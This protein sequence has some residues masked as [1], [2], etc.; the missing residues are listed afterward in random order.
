M[1]PSSL[2][3]DRGV[4]AGVRV[5]DFGRYVAGPYCAT[6]LGDFGAEVIRIEKREGS[7]DRFL[8]PVSAEGEGALFLQMNRN[9]QSMTLDPASEAG[10]EVV[11]RL[12]STADVVVVNMPADA[13]AA[14]GLDYPTLQGLNPGIILVNLSAFGKDGPWRDRLGFDSIGQA[15]SGAVHL[16]GEPDRPYRA[17]VNWVDYATA[18]H[19]AF[20]V[21]IALR[22][23]TQSGLGQEVSGALLATAVALNNG[24]LIEQALTAP[25]WQAIG[26]RSFTS[27]PTDLFRTLDGWIAVHVVGQPLFRRWAR[28]MGDAAHWLDD[29]RFADDSSRG[30]N[31]AALSE[32]MSAWC[33]DKTRD[34]ALDALAAAK[35]P[36]GPVLSPAEVLVHP[37]VAALGLLQ[38]VDYPGLPS[39]APLAGAPVFLSRTPAEI[40]RRPPQL[41]EHTEDVLASL[42]YDAQAISELRRL[43]AI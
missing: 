26:N 29:P 39:P 5:L 17:Q 11:R 33:A 6:L 9:K 13:V 14:M 34:E 24:P 15:M 8:I 41:G 16:S 36:A 22:E 18:L 42:G 25:N 1:E 4:L 7:E 20:G 35:I 21:L 38:D 2:P 23:R 31:G 32:R 27:G 12:V 37:Q 10:R 19:L 28:L 30:L 40:R 43:G 3:Q